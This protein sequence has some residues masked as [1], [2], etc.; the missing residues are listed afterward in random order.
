MKIISTT[1]LSYYSEDWEC[2]VNK[3]ISLIES[4]G[5]YAV[6]IAE[7]DKEY[8]YVERFEIIKHAYS[9]DEAMSEYKN[10]GGEI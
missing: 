2:E 10:Y 6:I 9:L 4:C 8:E 7:N 3:S 1:D 5:M